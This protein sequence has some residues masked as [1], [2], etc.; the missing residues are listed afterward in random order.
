M[1]NAADTVRLA[2]EIEPSDL[3][4]Y[5]DVPREVA[6]RMQNPTREQ[7]DHPLEVEIHSPREFTVEFGGVTYKADTELD[8]APISVRVAD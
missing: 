3:T 4:L 2:V 1:S 7:A 6:E 8:F 5:I